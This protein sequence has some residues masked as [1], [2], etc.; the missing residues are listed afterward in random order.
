MT[1]ATVKKL[2]SIYPSIRFFSLSG[3]GE[4]TLCDGFVDV[5]N[6]L[7]Q[8]GKH[9]EV[10]T[11]GTNPEKLLSLVFEPDSISI[12]LY[13]YDDKSYLA[14]TGAP[15]YSKVIEGYLKLR[16]KLRNVGF[17]WI[18]TRE[19]YRQL[20]HLL[21]LCDRL[22]PAFL[23]LVNYIASSHEGRE[24]ERI[25]TVKDTEIA[26]YLEDVCAGRT[27]VKVK[28]IL[29]DF[30]NP[31]YHCTSYARKINV[32]GDGNIGGC[33]RQVPPSS[34]FGNIFRDE[35]PYNSPEMRRLRRIAQQRRHPHAECHLCFGSWA[36]TAGRFTEL[37]DSIRSIL[38]RL[39]SIWQV[40]GRSTLA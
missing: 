38:T 36:S 2:L 10:V 19:N 9:V 18:V 26:D 4:P 40:G 20:D 13:G 1:V 28:P 14:Y 22:Q 16:D 5:V 12:S 8:K 39:H 29:V 35:D 6:F 17:S 25:I 27:Y 30:D 24:I 21:P 33:Q 34:H 11:N 37:K 15:A 3:Q 7:K 31:Q 23:H 32:D